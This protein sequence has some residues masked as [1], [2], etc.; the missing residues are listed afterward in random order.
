M[1][2]ADE[3]LDLLKRKRRASWTNN[4]GVWWTL[5]EGG[6]RGLYALI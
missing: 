2:V 4:R 6:S 1:I 3:I 5:S